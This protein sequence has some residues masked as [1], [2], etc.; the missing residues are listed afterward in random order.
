MANANNKKEILQ[1]NLLDAGCS[2]EQ[3]RDCMALAENGN[4]LRMIELLGKYKEDM[5]ATVHRK[6]KCIDCLDFLIYRLKK[7]CK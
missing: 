7:E 6:E 5:L 4:I 1:Q 3:V 2:E